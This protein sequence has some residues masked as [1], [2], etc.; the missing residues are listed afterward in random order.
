MHASDV[1]PF[2][3]SG[4]CCQ[5]LFND[6]GHIRDAGSGEE[7]STEPAGAAGLSAPRVS[8][9][10]TLPSLPRRPARKQ[11]TTRPPGPNSPSCP[12]RRPLR[13][14]P[15]TGAGG[16]LLRHK[17]DHVPPLPCSSPLPRH[18]CQ[19][20]PQPGG[21]SV[22]RSPASHR[23]RLLHPHVPSPPAAQTPRRSM[24]LPGSRPPQG[25]ALADPR[26]GP[27]FPRVPRGALPH[28]C[29]R[30]S[31]DLSDTFPNSSPCTRSFRNCS[32]PPTHSAL[33]PA[34]L[35]LALI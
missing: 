16:L 12:R 7:R 11:G 20:P 21:P 25:L 9:R 1:I 5:R 6:A 29:Q 15:H 8:L 31:T 32:L 27:P 24:N 14:T 30:R 2:D 35:S 34:C 28:I 18:G 26:P 22:V 13:S 3:C 23:L 19:S 4:T 33:F 17:S 10:E